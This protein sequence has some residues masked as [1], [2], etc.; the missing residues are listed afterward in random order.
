M[1]HAFFV[2]TMGQEV[3]PAQPEPHVGN[4][5]SLDGELNLKKQISNVEISNGMAWSADN[6]VMYYT[7]SLP[8]Q[9]YA[10]DFDVLAGNISKCV[11]FFK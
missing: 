1:M 8:R 2:G 6:S 11:W 4:L 10:Y 9:I 7:D 3:K 5:Y